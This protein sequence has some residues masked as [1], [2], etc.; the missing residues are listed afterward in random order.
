MAFYNEHET[1]QNVSIRLVLGGKVISTIG[2][3]ENRRELRCI[4]TW[5]IEEFLYLSV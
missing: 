3:Q 2:L 4:S 5:Q 1:A